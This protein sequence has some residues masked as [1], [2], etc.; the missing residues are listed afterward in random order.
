M[1]ANG[2]ISHVMRNSRFSKVV[3][4]LRMEE[5]VGFESGNWVRR[6]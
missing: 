3:F 4:W 2:K 5:G 6:G 1:K